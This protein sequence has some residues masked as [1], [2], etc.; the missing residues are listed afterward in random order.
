MKQTDIQSVSIDYDAFIKINLPTRI[1]QSDDTMS[2]VAEKNTW[3]KSEDGANAKGVV[4]TE[5]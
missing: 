5:P 2:E 1:N 4:L 3:L